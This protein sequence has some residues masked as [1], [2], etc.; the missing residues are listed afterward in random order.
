MFPSLIQLP[1]IVTDFSLA[2]HLVSM[3]SLALS[4]L[5]SLALPPCVSNLR[6]LNMAEAQNNPVWQ[7]TKS[8]SLFFFFLIYT[9]F[10]CLI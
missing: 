6:I 1:N 9:V 2:C 3:S 5:T 8:L 10:V 4:A 7:I